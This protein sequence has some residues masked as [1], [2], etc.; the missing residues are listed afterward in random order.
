MAGPA[1]E[2]HTRAEE[3]YVSG[4]V[5]TTFTAAA[6]LLLPAWEAVMWHVPAAEKVTFAPEM[7]QTPV[8]AKLIA[9]EALDDAVAVKASVVVFEPIAGKVIT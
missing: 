3:V 1:T 4:N 8:V 5:G 2:Q 9:S 6:C 7:V